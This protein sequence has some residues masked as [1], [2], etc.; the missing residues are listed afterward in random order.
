MATL[1]QQRVAE[2]VI[3]QIKKGKKVSVGRAMR[4]VGYSPS[5]WRT[6]KILTRSDAWKELMEKYL[7]DERLSKVHEG[8]LQSTT[9]DHMMF[10]LGPKVHE[11]GKEDP[12]QLSDEDIKK[13]LADVNCKV[14]QVVHG[15]TARHVY[16][17]AADNKARKD[18][19]DMAYK[20]K[21]RYAPEKSINVNIEVESDD[22]IKTITQEL[23]EIHR[24]ASFSGDGRSPSVVGQEVQ[25]QK[26]DGEAAGV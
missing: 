14:R 24:R 8:L 7:D 19:L 12:T 5:L 6:P 10:P 4:E 13:M 23:N 2:K 16:F 21:G 22:V 25:N 9:L 1:N 3:A 11:K 26:R 20:L 18:G 17:W 15:E